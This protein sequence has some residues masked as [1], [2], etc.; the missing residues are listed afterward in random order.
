M[1]NPVTK[2]TV[3]CGAGALFA[4][5]TAGEG[6][7]VTVAF[8]AREAKGCGVGWFLGWTYDHIFGG[9]TTTP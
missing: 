4:Y 2:F 5:A 6:A 3:L 1:T 9:K 8:L 7:P